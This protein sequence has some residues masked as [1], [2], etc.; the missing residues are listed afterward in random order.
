MSLGDV[1]ED[2]FGDVFA[3]VLRLMSSGM[4]GDSLEGV[5]GGCLG[6]GAWV[7]CY[8]VACLHSG[9]WPVSGALDLLCWFCSTCHLLV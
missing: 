6:V 9:S 2:V 5:L 8:V 1:F 4:T 3:V 7:L